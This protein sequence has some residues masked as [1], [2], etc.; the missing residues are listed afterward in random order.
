[1]TGRQI[2]EALSRLAM[3]F[4]PVQGRLLPRCLLPKSTGD[5]IVVSADA[6]RMSLLA[7]D[8]LASVEVA[9]IDAACPGRTKE[10]VKGDAGTGSAME[11]LP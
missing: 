8:E 4:G 2:T 3:Q 9:D 6:P 11:M 10:Y 7:K 1:M 5:A